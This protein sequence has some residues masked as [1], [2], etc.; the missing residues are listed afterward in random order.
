MQCA[1]F[2]VSTRHLSHPSH[3]ITSRPPGARP[4]MKPTLQHCFGQV[5]DKYAPD[6]IITEMT[7]KRA[8]KEIHMDAVTSYLEGRALNCVL[9]ALAPEVHPDEELLPRVCRAT[10][11]QLRADFCKELQTY[12]KFI[13]VTDDNS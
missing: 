6:G 7:L 13:N 10:M 1:Q 3:E 5:A 2:M 4:D 8:I 12:Q 11:T 9:G